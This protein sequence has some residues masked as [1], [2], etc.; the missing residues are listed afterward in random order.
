MWEPNPRAFGVTG[1]WR[2]ARGALR[3]VES[4]SVAAG[5]AAMLGGEGASVFVARAESSGSRVK[6]ACAGV[7]AVS[8]PMIVRAAG[9]RMRSSIVP[10]G[11]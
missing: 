11:V 1:S 6:S 8:K 4:W 5:A 2:W 7:L 3:G 9:V 10:R